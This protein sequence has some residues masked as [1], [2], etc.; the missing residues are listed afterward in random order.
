MVVEGIRVLV[1]L[2]DVRGRRN[3]KKEATHVDDGSWEERNALLELDK[4]GSSAFAWVCLA[5]SVVCSNLQ[6]QMISLVSCSSVVLR[7]QRLS[8]ITCGGRKE[9]EET[10]KA[11]GICIVQQTLVGA[12]GLA[13]V[14]DFAS[15]TTSAGRRKLVQKVHG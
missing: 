9:E 2:L 8:R 3:E 15:N 14:Y 6:V 13:A 10:S 4:F 11:T 12:R 1:L 7:Y 5:S